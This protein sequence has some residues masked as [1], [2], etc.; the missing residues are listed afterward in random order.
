MK[1]RT[2]LT[3][4]LAS[5]LSAAAFAANALTYTFSYVD[6]ADSVSGFFVTDATGTA[7]SGFATFDT[8]ELGDFSASL[9]PGA[10]S[11]SS[12]IYDNLFP[13][14]NPGLLF[15]NATT[16]INIFTNVPI[17]AGLGSTPDV[18]FY[19]GPINSG[20]YNISDTT[21]TLTIAVPEP[22]VWAMMLVGFG[23][24]GTTMR[25][26]RAIATAG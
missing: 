3:L 5:A 7:T 20:V 17:L 26:R 22:A 10:G 13:V 16:E 2:F 14:D 25:R 8:T 15:E 21:G 24:I 23:G 11:D 6:G 12:F 19:A 4:G 9:F 18:N 1:F